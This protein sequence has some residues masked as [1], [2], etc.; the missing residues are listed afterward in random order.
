MGAA[1]SSRSTLRGPLPR[2]RSGRV[3]SPCAP[4]VRYVFSREGVAIEDFRGLFS[5]GLR[6]LHADPAVPPYV[7]FCTFQPRAVKASLIAHGYRVA[8]PG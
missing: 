3:N 2:W 5:P 8:A 4:G 1:T 6:F 7:V